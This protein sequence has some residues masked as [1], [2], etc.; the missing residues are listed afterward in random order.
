[1]ELSEQVHGPN[2][3]EKTKEGSPWTCLAIGSELVF[4]KRR[5]RRTHSRRFAT[6][7]RLGSA[8]SVW[9]AS[10]LSALSLRGGAGGDRFA[11]AQL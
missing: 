11:R 10:D 2:A 5:W 6:A 4:G 3:C 8:R 7:G 9:T 1:M